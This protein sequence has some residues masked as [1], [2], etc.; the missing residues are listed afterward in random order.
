MAAESIAMLPWTISSS[1]PSDHRLLPRGLSVSHT[2]S[3]GLSRNCVVARY[4]AT[5][6]SL[7]FSNHSL[8]KCLPP[9]KAL[10]AAENQTV[11][12]TPLTGDDKVGV[13]LLNLG[14]P[15]TL[16]DVQP[17][18]FNLFA[19]PVTSSSSC[20]L[21]HWV[22][23]RVHEF[24]NFKMYYACEMLYWHRAFECVA[25]LFNLK[26][27]LIGEFW[28][29]AMNLETLTCVWNYVL[30]LWFWVEVTIGQDIIRLPRLFRFLQKPL[31]Q[32]ISVLRA[33]K[34]KEGYAAIGGGSPLRT[35]TDAQVWPL[36]VSSHSLKCSWFSCRKPSDLSLLEMVSLFRQKSWGSLFGRRMSQQKC[37]WVCVI[38]IH[39]LKKL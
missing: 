21:N 34:S 11:N 37:M 23:H 19:D 15:E 1:I 7:L 33:P 35:I 16:D 36:L 2:Q 39:L 29:K 4:S 32:F 5:Q 38:G 3:S 22:L 13:L 9:L 27:C 14:G 12:T 6:S 26:P 25:F 10:V 24:R 31:A 17:F 28:V 20:L 30:A 8:R 18:L